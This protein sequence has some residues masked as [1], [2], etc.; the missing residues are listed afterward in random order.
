M[1]FIRNFE[2][3]QGPGMKCILPKYLSV[4]VSFSLDYY[5]QCH[6][7]VILWPLHCWVPVR[8]VG[9]WGTTL[10]LITPSSALDDSVHLSGHKY[11]RIKSTNLLLIKVI[12]RKG[13]VCPIFWL[14]T[15]WSDLPNIS[16]FV[17]VQQVCPGSLVPTF[18]SPKRQYQK[19]RKRQEDSSN[20][21][22]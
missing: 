12:G 9:Q 10:T 8:Y 16:S 13:L 19:Y 21:I 2:S 6:N 18:E 15:P 3:I 11:Q 5:Y 22:E 20:L 4:L 17:F 1:G 7:V 14:L